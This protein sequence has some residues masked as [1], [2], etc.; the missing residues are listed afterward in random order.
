MAPLPFERAANACGTARAGHDFS[1]S[2]G[3]TNL[4]SHPS[5]MRHLWPL[6]EFFDVRHI[7]QISYPQSVRLLSPLY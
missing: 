2:P 1:G 7:G 6:I 4:I 3:Q 5:L